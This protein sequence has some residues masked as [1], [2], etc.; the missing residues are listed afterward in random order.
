M[1]VSVIH[2]K[3][4]WKYSFYAKGTIK[5]KFYTN[6]RILRVDT[7]VSHDEFAYGDLPWLNA[8]IV[9]IPYKVAIICKYTFAI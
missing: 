3:S 1:L 2:F 8:K 4:P 7:M 5:S 6:N 9:S